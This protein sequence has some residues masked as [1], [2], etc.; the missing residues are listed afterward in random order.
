V[1]LAYVS[2]HWRDW[3]LY[4]VFFLATGV[5]QVVY[6]PLVLRRPTAL[7]ALAGIAVN[8]SIVAMYFVSRTIGIPLG[9]HLHVKERVGTIDLATTAGEIV[10]VGA[11]LLLLGART[12]H[13][14][15]NAMLVTGLALWALRLTG[16]IQ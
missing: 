3:W 4:G 10:L 7:V 9:P 14:L 1:H 5:F 15:V 11:L 2:S 16:G 6:G 13:W 8:I 12:R